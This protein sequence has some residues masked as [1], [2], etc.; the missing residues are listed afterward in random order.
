MR[1]LVRLVRSASEAIESTPIGVGAWCALFFGIVLVRNLLEGFSGSLPLARPID[2]FL[3]YPLAFI[4]PLLTLAILLSLGSGIALAR[5]TRIMLVMWSLVLLPPLVDLVASGMAEQSQAAHIGYAPLFRGQ[6][7]DRLVH[8]FNPA[9]GFAGTTTG[10][11]VECLLEVVLAFAYVAIKRRRPGLGLAAGALTAAAVYV[12][13]LLYFTWPYH[14]YNLVTA[15]ADASQAGMRLFMVDQG[16]TAR[17]LFDR[18]SQPSGALHSLLLALV[19][20]LWMLRH[21]RAGAAALIRACGPGVIVAGAA[22]GAGA[23]FGAGRFVTA[24]G[25]PFAPSFLDALF[26]ACVLVAGAAA[27]MPGR[28]LGTSPAAATLSAAERRGAIVASLAVAAAAS[29]MVSYAVFSLVS[30]VLALSI[31]RAQEPFRTDRIPVV[32][33]TLRGLQVVALALAGCALFARGQTIA[34]LPRGLAILGLLA[35]FLAAFHG[36]GRGPLAELAARG[37]WVAPWSAA[38]PAW[39]RPAHWLGTRVATLAAAARPLLPFLPLAAPWCLW[40]AYPGAS[41]LAA[42]CAATCALYLGALLA[43]SLRGV[44]A[45]LVLTLGCALAFGSLGDDPR[46]VGEEVVET[47]ALRAQLA[48]ADRLLYS[49]H[50]E[51]AL[52]QYEQVMALRPRGFGAYARAIDVRARM[53]D[54]ETATAYA[55][56]A[57]EALPASLPA[58]AALAGLRA[59]AGDYPAACAAYARAVERD[60]TPDPELLRKAVLAA[61]LARDTR[62]A[63][64]FASLGLRQMPGDPLFRAG[65]LS[66]RIELLGSAPAES[67]EVFRERARRSSGDA[68]VDARFLEAAAELAA[69]NAAAAAALLAELAEERPADPLPLYLG[70]LAELSARRPRPAR[71]RVDR[72][73]ELRPEFPLAHALRAR[74]DAGLGDLSAAAR[75]LARALKLDPQQPDLHVELAL[76]RLRALDPAAAFA[77]LADLPP[78][79]ESRARKSALEEGITTYLRGLREAGDGAALAALPEQLRRSGLADPAVLTQVARVLAAIGAMPLSAEVFELAQ[80]RASGDPRAFVQHGQLLLRAGRADQAVRVFLAA[81][82]AGA[83]A[84][85]RI[86]QLLAQAYDAAGRPDLAAAARRRHGELQVEELGAE[87]LGGE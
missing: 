42:I 36:A 45:A 40:A 14:A 85:P 84:R 15:A 6:Y 21:R 77:G 86:Y 69:G 48:L 7:L 58:A 38:L 30:V 47:P 3:H 78:R 71:Q 37:D 28:L 82:D 51:L 31:L 46:V 76:I 25:Q 55:E 32:G 63:L 10:I 64:H 66:A 1:S 35:A 72:F 18:I 16:L 19:A 62:A 53:D 80:A 70:S 57:A 17:A 74:I 22:V 12:V 81:V 68:A 52:V 9:R 67:L 43:P 61:N 34:L 27:T 59:Q 24:A 79:W 2:F 60:A 87:L 49:D 8:F 11:R 41:A 39:R 5:V 50:V 56:R 65:E 20:G 4:N 83:G 75:D 26:I 13:S 73:L 54:L 23:A 33:Q 29:W 44:P